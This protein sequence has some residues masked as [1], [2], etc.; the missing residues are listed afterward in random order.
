METLEGRVQMQMQR[1]QQK[2]KFQE[3]RQQLLERVIHAESGL[4]A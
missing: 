3:Q 4:A 1:M 2:A